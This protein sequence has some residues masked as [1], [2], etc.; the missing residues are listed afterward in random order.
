MA[1]FFYSSFILNYDVRNLSGF[2]ST[3]KDGTV[4]IV[5]NESSVYTVSFDLVNELNESVTG[6]YTGYLV[7]YN[8]DIDN[9][10]SQNRK[11]F[12]YK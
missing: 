1:H 7:Y 3:I 4:N 12:R 6:Q 2:S 5:R 10:S 9:K 8:N 11:L